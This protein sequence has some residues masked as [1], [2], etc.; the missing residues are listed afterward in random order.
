MDSLPQ[1]LQFPG[2]AD[3]ISRAFS[4]ER[5]LAREFAD[6]FKM[7]NM[8]KDMAV[9][10]FSGMKALGHKYFSSVS[11]VLQQDKKKMLKE[12]RL[13]VKENLL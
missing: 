5:S 3:F 8:S 9:F 2:A 10:Q 4:G 7:M 6:I 1:K 11:Y 12:L 13:L